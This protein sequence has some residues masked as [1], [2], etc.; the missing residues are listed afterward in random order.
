MVDDRLLDLGVS[1]RLQL[2]GAFVFLTGCFQRPIAALQSK[3]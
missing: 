1:D 2:S 3:I